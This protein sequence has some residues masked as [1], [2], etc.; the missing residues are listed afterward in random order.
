MWP[1]DC[2]FPQTPLTWPP[3]P[4]RPR[5]SE[6]GPAPILGNEHGSQQGFEKDSAAGFYFFNKFSTDPQSCSVPCATIEHM[7]VCVAY[8]SITLSPDKKEFDAFISY[9]KGS[10]SESEPV[11]PVSEDRLALKLFPEVLEN[12]YGYTLCLLERDVA[13]GGGRPTPKR[14]D[15]SKGGSM[16]ALHPPHTPGAGPSWR[17]VSLGL[18]GQQK[19]PGQTSV[20][21]VSLHPKGQSFLGSSL[22]FPVGGPAWG[23]CRPQMQH[24]P[25]AAGVWARPCLLYSDLPR[26]LTPPLS[27]PAVLLQE[28]PLRRQLRENCRGVT[29]Q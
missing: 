10:A 16:P 26:G 7:Q 4:R 5:A 6:R 2:T 18:N 24:G 21:H 8:T 9:A 20:H 19:T 17:A 27:R 11:F 15:S 29:G 23:H 14:S 3:Q 28:G 13:P 25:W 1:Q 22:S 12:K